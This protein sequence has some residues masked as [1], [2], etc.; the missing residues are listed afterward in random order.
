M[1]TRPDNKSER[2]FFFHGQIGSDRRGITVLSSV[3]LFCFVISGVFARYVICYDFFYLSLFLFFFLFLF[4]F[5]FSPSGFFSL[6][7]RAPSVIIDRE[8]FMLIVHT[9]FWLDLAVTSVQKIDDGVSLL[10]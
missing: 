1:R 7:Y 2:R 6:A 5:V 4:S 8:T 9:R 10:N 3:I